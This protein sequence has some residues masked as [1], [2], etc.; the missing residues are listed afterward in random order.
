MW[1]QAEG[2]Y[3]AVNRGAMSAAIDGYLLLGPFF[4]PNGIVGL[5]LVVMAWGKLSG[6]FM[7]GRAKQELLV[8]N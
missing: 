6:S 4:H 3:A 1:Q 8:L 7:T 5:M 2:T